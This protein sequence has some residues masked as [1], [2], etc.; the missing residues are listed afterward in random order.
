MIDMGRSRLSIPR[1]GG[2]GW[3][4]K[5]SSGWYRCDIAGATEHV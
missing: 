5:H 1:P 2:K 3:N 4:M